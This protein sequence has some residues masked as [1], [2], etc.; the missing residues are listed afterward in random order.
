MIR[1]APPGGCLRNLSQWFDYQL[2]S[3]HKEEVCLMERYCQTEGTVT[4][5]VQE[6]RSLDYSLWH[7]SPLYNK[8]SLPSSSILNVGAHELAAG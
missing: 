1:L 8:H 6:L 3:P 4:V 2:S 7:M 5:A